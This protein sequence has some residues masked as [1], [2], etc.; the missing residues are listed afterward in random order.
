MRS[1]EPNT[2]PIQPNIIHVGKI[3][4]L[5]TSNPKSHPNQIPH[6]SR[7]SNFDAERSEASKFDVS[8]PSVAR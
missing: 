5:E 7:N 1:I 8:L 2:H 3:L 4:I 6:P